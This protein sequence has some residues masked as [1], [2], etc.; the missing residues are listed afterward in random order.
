MHICIQLNAH[1]DIVL[2][3]H[4][5]HITQGFIYN[6]ID[7]EL[8]EFL[9]SKG[10]GD[11]RK[12]KL[13]CFSNIIGKSHIDSEHNNIVF[14]TP[15]KLEVSS[16]DEYFCESFANTILKKEVKLG[17]N[18]LEIES[19]EISRQDVLE[20]NIVL[21]TLSPITAYSTLLRP[22]GRK[23]TCF[24]QPGEEDFNRIVEENLRKKYNAYTGM[25]PPNDRMHFTPLTSPRLHIVKYKGFVI[26]GYSCKLSI[27]GPRQLLQIAVDT[28]L[29]SKN[30]QGFGCVKLL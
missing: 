15:I 11:S 21:Q 9:H 18:E 14:K 24:F 7:K 17:V 5:N 30:S 10:Y 23:Y 13:F 2:P 20:D 6:M 19:I 22:D 28:G 27:K 1:K 26:K 4:Y 29:G 16:P 12:F 3:I 25:Q 8:S